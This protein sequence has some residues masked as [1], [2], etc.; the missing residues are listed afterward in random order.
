MTLTWQKRRLRR[1]AELIRPIPHMYFSHIPILTRKCIFYTLPPHMERVMNDLIHAFTPAWPVGR[2]FTGARIAD[3]AKRFI[4]VHGERHGRM[5]IPDEGLDTVGLIEAVAERLASRSRST[6]TGRCMAAS[7]TCW[8]SPSK[9]PRRAMCWNSTSPRRGA[10]GRLATS[11]PFSAS[12][13]RPWPRTPRSSAC[14]TPCASAGST[15]CGA[16]ICGAPGASTPGANRDRPCRHPRPHR[17]PPQA[18]GR[19]RS[20]EPGHRT[21]APRTGH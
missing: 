19:R 3:I 12:A 6:L 4:G 21:P 15:G 14:R 20:L 2:T 5:T 9:R 11:W 7:S 13:N 8:K 17:R 10:D 18:S 1:A 16:T